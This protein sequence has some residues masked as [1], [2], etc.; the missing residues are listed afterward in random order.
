MYS[1]PQPCGKVRKI[2][3][4]L[5]IFK[6]VKLNIVWCCIMIVLCCQGA[7]ECVYKCLTQSAKTLKCVSLL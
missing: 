4:V 5:V 2:Y 6:K 1:F 3:G 7:V